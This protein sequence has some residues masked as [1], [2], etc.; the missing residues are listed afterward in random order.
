MASGSPL[1]F[2]IGFDALITVKKDALG[3]CVSGAVGLLPLVGW[4]IQELDGMASI[5]E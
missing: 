4:N 2:C 1:K 3:W 5:Q